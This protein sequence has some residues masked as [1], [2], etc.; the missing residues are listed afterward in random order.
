M[1]DPC[2]EGKGDSSGDGS[3]GKD[4]GKTGEDDGK[5][6]ED[7]GKTGKEDD[8]ETRDDEVRDGVQND[9]LD[10]GRTEGSGFRLGED[11]VDSTSRPDEMGGL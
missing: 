2:G 4:D 11:I 3:A 10:D 1:G 7:D 6:G 9:D 8:G 5:T